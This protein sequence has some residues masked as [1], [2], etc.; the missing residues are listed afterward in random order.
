MSQIHTLSEAGYRWVIAAACATILAVV[1]GQLVNGVSVYFVPLEAEFGWSRADIALINTIGL[2]G[3]G[4]G[5]IFFGAM[6]NRI[7]AR[8]IAL[9]GVV[10][11]AFA[12]LMASRA[13]AL[14]Q[15]YVLFFLAGVFGGGALSAPLMA[16]V[17]NWFK[18]GAGL[19]IGIVAA[20]QALGQGAVPFTGAFLIEDYGWRDALKIQGAVTLIALA[21][22]ALLLR[23]PPRVNSSVFR[24]SE[25]SPTG[26]P[27]WMITAW[28]SVAVIFCCICMA[29]PLI[30]LVPYMQACGL[31]ATDA[32]SVLFLMLM[33]AIAGRAAFG[34][35]A[36]RI[37]ALQ[38]WLLA[39]AW[40][41]AL[42]FGFTQFDQLFA[43]YAFAALY[44][45][46]YAGVMTS[47][48][49]TVR[50]LCAPAKRAGTMGI[51]VAFA[52]VG[53]GAGGWQGG[54]FFDLTGAYTWTF[55]IAALAGLVNLAIVG[56][57]FMAI[58]TN[59]NAD[60]AVPA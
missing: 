44:G 27:N 16:L 8:R 15:F 51:V 32:G 25:Q 53:H 4:V 17:G 10:S 46:G 7:G 29:V 22:L 43:L 28:L 37:G 19:A 5:S 56:L 38:A 60:D 52:Y 21:P 3:L 59:A 33:V 35:L 18:V 55:G 34:W 49:V 11:M 50:N 47:V 40:Q 31:P 13:D 23:D 41:T 1:M 9:T 26:L 36:D 54:Y 14:W 12:T 2:V 57:L 24:A 20:G 6:A 30:H 48:L 42:V 39:S 45:F 58:Q